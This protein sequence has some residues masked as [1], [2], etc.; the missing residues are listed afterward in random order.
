MKD[1]YIKE[2]IMRGL[3][4]LAITFA[5]LWG[6]QT[7]KSSPIPEMQVT[8]ITPQAATEKPWEVVTEALTFIEVLRKACR[9]DGYFN[10][11]YQGVMERYRC[12]PDES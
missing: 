5:S 1:Y 11:K 6:C 8:H 3:A 9:D 12:S 2:W 10:I 4:I 7:L